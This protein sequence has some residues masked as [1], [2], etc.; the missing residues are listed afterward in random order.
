MK[1]NVLIKKYVPI[2]FSF[3]ASLIRLFFN[4][5]ISNGLVVC[6][7]NLLTTPFAPP[8]KWNM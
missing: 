6:L 5:I 1:F 7:E 2:N 4:L 8:K 3:C